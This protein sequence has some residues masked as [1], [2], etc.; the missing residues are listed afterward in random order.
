MLEELLRDL[1]N[2][3]DIIAAISNGNAVAEVA[4]SNLPIKVS[5]E[6]IRVGIE[7][8]SHIHIKKNAIRFVQFLREVK[9]NNRMSFSIRL[10]DANKERI[11]AIYF[12]KMYDG[13]Q[14][15]RERVERYED[16]FKRYGSRDIIDLVDR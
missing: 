15:K 8:E 14:L 2:E 16:I 11:L 7:G 1:T 6:W 3:E 13:E 9:S 5:E 12:V 10:L 4:I